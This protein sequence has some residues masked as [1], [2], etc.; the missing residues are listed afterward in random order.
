MLTQS[1]LV[2]C[3]VMQSLKAPFLSSLE[4]IC[5]LSCPTIHHV[6]SKARPALARALSTCLHSILHENT[7][8]SWKKL[9]ML[10]KCLV[11][12]PKRRG[13]HHKPCSIER[14][15]DQW[16]KGEYHLL[17]QRAAS[18]TNG[19]FRQ[20]QQENNERKVKNSVALA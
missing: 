19:K 5:K 14:L 4:D 10:P 12:S 7:E 3:L 16:L 17:W 13:R 8:D 1:R 11:S 20:R 18:Q 2:V 9:F 15:C 6:P